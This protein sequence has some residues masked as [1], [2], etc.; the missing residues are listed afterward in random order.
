MAAPAPAAEGP[1]MGCPGPE[2]LVIV[3]PA[4]PACNSPADL[5]RIGL[6]GDTDRPCIR[7]MLPAGTPPGHAMAPACPAAGVTALPATPGRRKAPAP[8]AGGAGAALAGKRGPL[9]RGSTSADGAGTGGLPR[10]AAR[11]RRGERAWSGRN[12]S[13]VRGVPP[14]AAAFAAMVA[15][16]G[17]PGAVATA[18]AAAALG[19]PVGARGTAA[20]G[21]ATAAGAKGAIQ[22]DNTAGAPS[23]ALLTLVLVQ[24]WWGVGR[25]DHRA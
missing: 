6:M 19:T 23:R 9:W 4:V 1:A 16:G 10:G 13:T 8:A 24:L 5:T 14:T 17:P 18:T 12:S 3:P 11:A 22:R 2:G 7:L 25:Q 15:P 21:A 20:A